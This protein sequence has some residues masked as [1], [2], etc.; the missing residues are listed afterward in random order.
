M[1]PRIE[2]TKLFSAE[3]RVHIKPHITGVNVSAAY[4]AMSR[5][6]E[7]LREAYNVE[8]RITCEEEAPTRQYAITFTSSQNRIRIRRAAQ[9][10]ATWISNAPEWAPV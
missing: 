4:G 7:K 1:R 6:A 10:M 2:I 3:I 5:T 9:E 8:L